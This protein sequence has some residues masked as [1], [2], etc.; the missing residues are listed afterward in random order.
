[1]LQFPPASDEVQVAIEQCLR[2][3]DLAPK[4]KGNIRSLMHLGEFDFEEMTLLVQRSIV[5]GTVDEEKTEY[6]RDRVPL[7]E[8]LAELLLEWKGKSPSRRLPHPTRAT[9]MRFG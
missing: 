6:S 8:H 1:M 3:L 5:H 9:K 7:D 2:S 4:T